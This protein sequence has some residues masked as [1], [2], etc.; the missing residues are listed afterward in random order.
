MPYDP[1]LL[2]RR[3]LGLRAASVAATAAV[4]GCVLPAEVTTESR[5]ATGGTAVMARVYPDP[6]TKAPAS[7]PL[8][9][10][11]MAGPCYAETLE[12]RD[13]SEGLDGLPV[14]LAFLVVDETCAPVDGAVVDI[15]HTSPQGLYSG[16]DADPMCTRA[17]PEALAARWFRGTQTTDAR[18]RTEF[19]TCFPGWY[20]GRT[21]HIHFAVRRGRDEYVVSQLIFEQALVDEVFATHPV[22]RPHGAP[23]TTNAADFIVSG[24]IP[25]HTV[26]VRRMEDGVMLAWKVLVVRSSLA[27]PLCFEG[28]GEPW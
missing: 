24:A 25:A 13:V 16:R 8:L 22:Y 17:D 7:C 14:R 10:A 12:R 28:P 20:T 21:P 26:S 6:F 15:W 19:D 23:D 18:G 3:A 1:S 5:W 11:M 4:G 9:C 2:S 27:E